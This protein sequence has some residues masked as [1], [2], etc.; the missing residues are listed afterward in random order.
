MAIETLSSDLATTREKAEEEIEANRKLVESQ[1]LAIETLSRDLA[2]TREKACNLDGKVTT[3][4]EGLSQARMEQR[5]L[6][7]ALDAVYASTSWRIMSPVRVAVHSLRKLA[8]RLGN[9]TDQAQAVGGI[10]VTHREK[11]MDATADAGTV[12]SD[13]PPQN[14]PTYFAEYTRQILSL[15]RGSDDKNTDYVPKLAQNFGIFESSAED[16]RILLAS[17]SSYS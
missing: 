15:S 10:V 11:S 3:L 17:I 8:M 16:Y 2:L 9:K 1:Q 7:V 5:Q 4:V 6:R 14:T 12:A 13:N